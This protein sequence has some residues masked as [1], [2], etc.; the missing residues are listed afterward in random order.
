VLRFFG[1]TPSNK[2]VYLDQIF[3]LVYHLGF[4][5]KDAYSCPV[6]QRLWF[7]HRLK[8]EFEEAKKNNNP[9]ARARNQTKGSKTFTRSFM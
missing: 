9:P 5:Y 2:D 6:W 8:Q 4:S 7:I 1:L 3:L